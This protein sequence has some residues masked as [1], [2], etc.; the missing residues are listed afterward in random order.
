MIR[1]TG[2]FTVG[3]HEVDADNDQPQVNLQDGFISSVLFGIILLATAVTSFIF[4]YLTLEQTVRVSGTGTNSMQIVLMSAAIVT[5]LL[6]LCWGRAA[7][8]SDAP[9][10]TLPDLSR[11]VTSDRTLIRAVLA[12]FRR[13]IRRAMP[14]IGIIIFFLLSS[15]MELMYAAAHITCMSTFRRCSVGILSLYITSVTRHILKFFFMSISMAFCVRFYN[16]VCIRCT[17]VHYAL[18]TMVVACIAI[19]FQ[20]TLKECTRVLEIDI[21]LQCDS[22]LSNISGILCMHENTSFY[23]TLNDW[24]RYT[25]PLLVEFFLLV[26]EMLLHLFSATRSAQKIVRATNCTDIVVHSA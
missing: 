19:W 10:P 17:Y 15:P 12:W 9:K 7:R 22:P 1:F 11:N 13:K 16:R 26:I 5:M 20:T 18:V 3:H 24:D 25:E 14:V 2:P 21:H 6:M 23:N 8:L 4:Y